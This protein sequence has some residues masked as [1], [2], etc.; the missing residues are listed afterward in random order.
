[1]V[2]HDGHIETGSALAQDEIA[3][4]D[5]SGTRGSRIPG[6]E[7]R[8]EVLVPWI[9]AVVA[10]ALAGFFFLQVRSA[11][12]PAGDL[13]AV[14]E[15]AG[16]FALELTNWDASDGM[17]DTREAL[18][19]AGTETFA[20]DVDE[21]FGGT[22][23]L[24]ELEEIAARSEGEVEDVLVQSIEDD[25]AQALAVVVQRVST[26]LTDGAEVSLRYAR[27][28]LVHAG[29]DW[30]VDQVELVVDAL[31]QTADPNDQTGVPSGED[32]G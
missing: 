27:L 9:V 24:A 32:G 14:E 15:T 16:R 8:S 2:D 7:L 11:G 19:D 12:Q 23:D 17:A 25:R 21:L 30:R 29:G 28:D 31:Q 6:A 4:E 20:A 13:S 3:R 1:M 26:E 22:G 5:P 18:R 10:L